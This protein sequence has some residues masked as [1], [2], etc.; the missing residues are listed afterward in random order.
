MGIG[1]SRGTSRKSDIDLQKT[2]SE[3]A[4]NLFEEIDSNYDGLIT[5]AE[6]EQAYEQKPELIRMLSPSPTS[7]QATFASLDHDGSGTVNF[8]E[9]RDRMAFE[10]LRLGRSSLGDPPDWVIAEA[11]RASKGHGG[12]ARYMINSFKSSN[13]DAGAVPWERWSLEADGPDKP[14]RRITTSTSGEH[15]DAM[16]FRLHDDVADVHVKYERERQVRF[17]DKVD[18]REYYKKTAAIAEYPD[19]ATNAWGYNQQE[20]NSLSQMEEEKSAFRRQG[21]A[22]NDGIVEALD[23]ENY[24]FAEALISKHLHLLPA[25][26][27]LNALYLDWI[28]CHQNETKFSVTGFPINMETRGCWFKALEVQKYELAHRQ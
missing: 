8:E 15:L 12:K 19:D 28:D 26:I 16:E 14:S 2:P 9:V 25:M 27:K 11:V 20:A 10:T 22:E 23:Q 3:E 1:C 7:W 4:A 5:K 17:H 21:A 18:V 24:D 6:F 13:S